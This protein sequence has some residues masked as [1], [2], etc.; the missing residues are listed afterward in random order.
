LARTRGLDVFLLDSRTNDRSLVMTS[1]FSNLVLAGLCFSHR[2]LLLKHLDG[3]ADR[4]KKNLRLL[5]N[6]ASELATPCPARA[7]G[8]ASSTLFPWAQESCLK[9][10]EMTAGRIAAIPETFLGLRHGPM[11]FLDRATLVLCLVSG[12]RRRQLYELDLLRELKAKRLGN[13]SGIVP[14]GFSSEVIDTPV[15][16]CAH[17]L[18]DELRPPFEIVFS[19]LLAYRFSLASVLDPD[20]TSP[21]GVIN[22]VVDSVRLHGRAR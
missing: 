19:Q 13:V 9:L 6:L 14:P 15:Q 8:L 11:S 1:S 3:V 2:T 5:D 10:L 12:D 7:V 20:N 17:E 16:A 18:P 4:V 22:R 21:R